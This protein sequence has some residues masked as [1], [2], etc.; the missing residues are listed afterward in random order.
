MST[1]GSINVR[2][3]GVPD[4]PSLSEGSGTTMTQIEVQ[5]S[6]PE[7]YDSLITNYELRVSHGS[8]TE[9]HLLSETSWST[10]NNLAPRTERMI[11]PSSGA[12]SR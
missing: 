3:H 2:T 7:D 1:C 4:A 9:E 8:T 11:A 6:A 10:L 12:T 5:W